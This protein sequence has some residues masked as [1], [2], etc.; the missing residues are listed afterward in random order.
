M[1]AEVTE[2]EYLIARLL[3]DAW[4]MFLKLPKEHSMQDAEF[5]SAIHRCQELVLSRA[6]IR[7]IKER[8]KQEIVKRGASVPKS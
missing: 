4:D 1:I 7:A 6:G 3:G 5:C 8:D 2:Q